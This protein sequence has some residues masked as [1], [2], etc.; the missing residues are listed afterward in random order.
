MSD[1][2]AR[3]HELL[4]WAFGIICHCDPA[5]QHKVKDEDGRTGTDRLLTA[6]IIA[7]N[8]TKW[9]HS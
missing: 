4:D 8:G 6:I 3:L 5:P 2:E 7:Q 9:E 1:E